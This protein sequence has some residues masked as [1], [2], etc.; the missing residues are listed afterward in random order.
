M[1]NIRVF[2]SIMCIIFISIFQLLPP[3]FAVPI[4]W[5]NPSGGDWNNA[6]NW[7]P[8][9]VPAASDT[10]LFDLPATYPVQITLNPD[11]DCMCSILE[12][13]AG[14]VTFIHY[15]SMLDVRQ[16][17]NIGTAGT[18]ATMTLDSSF[19]VYEF[20]HFGME[21]GSQGTLI[22]N[23]LNFSIDLPFA[24]QPGGQVMGSGGSFQGRDVQNNGTISP[25]LGM[26]SAGII[27]IG[28]E[29][30]ASYRQ[31]GTGV[32]N[33]EVGGLNQG[34]E[35]DALIGGNPANESAY[36]GGT[37][38]VTLINGFVPSSGD[39]FVILNNLAVV[40]QFTTVNLPSS[41]SIAYESNRVKLVCTTPTPTP[42]PITWINPS[43]GDWNN[44][45]NWSPNMVPAASD[46]VLFDLP[47][48]YPVQITL[49]P[50]QDCM[51]SILEVQAG[52]VTFIHY[53][54]MLDVRQTVNIGTAGTPATMTL[55]SSFGVYEF[56]H[57]GMEVGSQ[58][59]LILNGLNFSIDLPFAIQPGGQVMGSGGSFQGR[60]VQ[61][62][63]TISPG[64]G[65]GSAGI[66]GIGTEVLASYRQSG[67]GVLNI[68]IG[69]LNQGT[70]FDALIGGNPAN[71]SAYL[72]GTLNVTLIN[73]FVPSPDDEFV[74]INNLAVVGQ[75]TTV[76]L[77]SSLSIAYESNRVK[78]IGI[79]PPTATP[80]PAPTRTPEPTASPTPIPP[81]SIPTT[82]PIGVTCIL[83]IFGVLFVVSRMSN[84]EIS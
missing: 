35:F 16:T 24:I 26:G 61:N 7:S 42:T 30:L 12:V 31:S 43:G 44:A 46:T 80:S 33:I 8:N 14:H 51:C 55:D 73:G 60:D 39:E 2:C 13:Q 1:F 74:I 65:M 21:V 27:G 71:E 63:G 34:T 25:G 79:E 62:N 67:T 3:V 23:G 36:L 20:R 69:G 75:F 81:P 82:T 28:T 57:F 22:L 45:S 64:L 37:L 29:V 50:D 4:T 5:I 78:L 15:G 84:P 59:T 66:I 32:L 77:P 56:R 11:Q 6:S 47:A 58:G 53:G 40:G 76:N 18:P 68:E 38:N 49:N 9:M 19:G 70:E 41:L 17:V 72:G 10:V 48:T 83:L 52:H 54:S